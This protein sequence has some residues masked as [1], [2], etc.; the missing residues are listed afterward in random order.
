MCH[1]RTHASTH[2]HIWNKSSRHVTF[3]QSQCWELNPQ[4]SR[5]QACTNINVTHMILWFIKPSHACIQRKSLQCMIWWEHDNMT[6]FHNSTSWCN[7]FFTFFICTYQV[8]PSLPSLF[9]NLCI[10]LLLCWECL[11]LVLIVLCIFVFPPLPCRVDSF[12][13]CV[14]IGCLRILWYTS[15]FF[16]RR[17]MTNNLRF[18]RKSTQTHKT[19]SHTSMVKILASCCIF[20]DMLPKV[21]GH[22]WTG[23][24]S[25]EE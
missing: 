3:Q 8:L 18:V 14:Y 10:R 4:K 16:S 17:L 13:L 19:F 23:H 21:R 9:C 6:T 11:P 7:Y 24:T 22:I 15:L 12:D 2:A 1:A 25:I 20:K 5:D